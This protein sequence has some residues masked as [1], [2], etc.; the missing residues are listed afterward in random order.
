MNARIPS[1][2]ALLLI[3]LCAIAGAAEVAKV[4]FPLKKSDWCIREHSTFRGLQPFMRH[5]YKLIAALLVVGYVSRICA[6]E[7]A[8]P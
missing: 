2:V 8:V 1:P 7:S 5:C 3:L 6:E 4:A